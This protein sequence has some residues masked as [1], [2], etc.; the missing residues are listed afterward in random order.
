[1][2]VL[3]E[4]C[5][6]VDVGKGLTA[7]AVRLLEC[8][9][10][11]VSSR[12]PTSTAR[13]MVEVLIDGERRPAVLAGLTEEGMR[14]KIAD[15]TRALKG[16]FSGH[17]AL[18]CQL[19]LEHLDHVEDMIA[20]LDA[21]VEQMM[22]PFR[23]QRELLTSIPGI[24]AQAS[25]GIV[26]EIGADRGDWLPTP[27]QQP[28]SWTG[29]CPGNHE[30]AAK[31]HR[32]KGNQHLQP[33]LVECA[34][35][36]VR[37]DGYLR[38]FYRRQVREFGGYHQPTCQKERNHRGGAQTDHPHLARADHRQPLSRS[39]RRLLHPVASTPRSKPA[40]S[41]PNSKPRETPSPSNPSSNHTNTRHQNTTRLRRVASPAVV[42]SI[43]V[44]AHHKGH[45]SGRATSTYIQHGCS[46]N[47][48]R[49]G[50]DLRCSQGIHS[51]WVRSTFIG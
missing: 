14:A 43:H 25:A 35:A 42:T 37:T 9:L 17:H 26:T 32:R 31:R 2:Q 5:A 36:A 51:F 28:A 50:A 47:E 41:S 13:A 27:P 12:R 19:Q 38:S 23:P 40:A 39:R 1:V 16:R 10:G 30:S 22:A 18:M 4:R 20:K 6:A 11:A 33:W 7:V 49:D 24:G 48:P 29:L 8:G 45:Q 34:W 46:Q 15:L 44:P 3:Y 21:Q